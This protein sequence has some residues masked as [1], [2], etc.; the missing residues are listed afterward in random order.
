MKFNVLLGGI[1]KKIGLSKLFINTTLGKIFTIS[2]NNELLIKDKARELLT[3]LSP[4]PEGTSYTTNRILDEK[5]DLK[6][7]VPAYNV[8]VYIDEC[9]GSIFSQKTDYTFS[10]VVINDGSTDNTRKILNKYERINNLQIIDQP[11]K[12]FSGARNR[13][14]KEIDSKYIMFVDSDDKLEQNAIQSLLKTAF[15]N[16]ADIVE[17]G[18]YNFGEKGVI[19]KNVHSDNKNINPI[20]NLRGFP[21]G[22]VIRSSLFANLKFPE[23]FWYEDTIFSYLI[24]P[25]CKNASTI[26]DIVYWYRYNPKGI[27]VTSVKNNKCIDTYWILEQMLED[28]EKLNI[29]KSQETYEM[30]LFQIHMN[31]K[32]TKY[33][34]EAIQ[35][36]LFVLSANL[37]Q[38]QFKNFYTQN[39]FYKK[40][41][42]ALRKNDFKEYFSFCI[43]FN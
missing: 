31:F 12:G 8:E 40:L 27:S 18:Y 15:E 19:S 11:N 10:V 37:L 23:G 26:S 6:I 42:Q 24:Y 32:R 16:D 14:L 25:Q 29:K 17:G 7:I 34:D 9:L 3:T 21:W 5:V 43:L 30:T 1:I 35:K 28:M 13:G 20:G 2:L 39:N 33:M 41:E 22:K 36:S 4:K 38:T